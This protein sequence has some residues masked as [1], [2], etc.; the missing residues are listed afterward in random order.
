MAARE[1][2][3]LA[4]LFAADHLGQMIK[5]EPT[6]LLLTAAKLVSRSLPTNRPITSTDIL[7]AAYQLLVAELP[8]EYVFKACALERLLFGR[9][10]PRTTAF[11]TE[12]RI[13]DSRADFLVVNGHAVVY[14]IKTRYDD[15]ARLDA[16]LTDYY[17]AFS[18]VTVFVDPLQIKAVT[19][20]V[21][22]HVG[23][24]VLSRRSSISVVRKP[25]SFRESLRPEAL[26][27]LLREPEYTAILHGRGFQLGSVDP[28]Y[29][30]VY[31]RDA[32]CTLPL[33]AVYPEV[34]AALKRRQDTARLAD[35]SATL[36]TSL[37]IAPFAHRMPREDWR[38]LSKV[39]NCQL[40]IT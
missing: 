11:Y 32:F 1:R 37:R 8:V 3:L 13:G 38:T 12:F 29:R 7:D 25:T 33:G 31:A 40:A 34:L 28:A 35:I 30:Y 39:L 21:P 9:H 10:S 22:E 5:G 14:E 4:S 36:P 15:L 18:H 27:R 23:I 19:N 20:S 26:F 2:E 6:P 24:S 17:R 16:Q